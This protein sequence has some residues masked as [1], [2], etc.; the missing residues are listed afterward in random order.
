MIPSV[1]R[2]PAAVAVAL[3][4]VSCGAHQAGRADGADPA[5]RSGRTTTAPARTATTPSSRPSA[6]TARPLARSVP[7][8][9]RIPAI[10]VDTPVIRLGL[11][12]DGSVQVPRSPH[13]TGRAG[14]GTR[15]HPARPV[16]R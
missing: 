14:T 1:R 12:P 13:T 4:L 2:A 5:G 6:N 8:G 15:R 3:L 10:G 7:V 9:L 11:A 16:L